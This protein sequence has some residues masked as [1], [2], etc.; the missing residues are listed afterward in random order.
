MKT[1]LPSEVYLLIIKRS[2]I[3]EAG[4]G[5]LQVLLA[6]CG[7][8][9]VNVLNL[10]LGLRCG[11]VYLELFGHDRS[12]KVESEERWG[13]VFDFPEQESLVRHSKK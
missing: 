1:A 11:L 8:V 6:V 13:C 12:F 7:S 5:N 9:S 2:N 4:K 10:E 3:S